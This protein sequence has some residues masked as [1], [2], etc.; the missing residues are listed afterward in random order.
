MRNKLNHIAYSQSKFVVS[1]MKALVSNPVFW[2]LSVI[3]NGSM[4]LGALVFYQLESGINPKLASFLDALWW[5]V[6]TVTTVGYGDITPITFWGKIVGIGMMIFGTVVFVSFTALFAAII[7]APE[8]TEFEEEFKE[9]EKS[10]R[11]S[12]KVPTKPL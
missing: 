10:V 2:L 6:A 8:I 9:L 11:Q 12:Q 1:R 3:G 5:S 7:L 4:I